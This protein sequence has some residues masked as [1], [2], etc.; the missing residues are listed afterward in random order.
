MG[1]NAAKGFDYGTGFDVAS[2]LGSQIIDP[3]E[4]DSD[5]RIV[6][7]RNHSGGIQGGI[8]NGAPVYFR[9][10]FKPVATLM[11]EVATVDDCG[12][13][14]VLKAA[15]RHD[16]CV[17]PRAVPVVEAMTAITLLDSMIVAGKY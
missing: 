5:G 8:S 16:P 14:T 1:I 6:T 11:R 2:M 15:G 7:T 17:V 3:F 9:V 10:A 13:P 12:N 4:T